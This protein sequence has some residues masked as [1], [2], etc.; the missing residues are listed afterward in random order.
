MSNKTLIASAA[1]L[2][3]GAASVFAG[4]NSYTGNVMLTTDYV[5][6]GVSQTQERGAIQGGFD[7]TFAN[8]LFAGVWASNVNFGTGADGASAEVDYYGGYS[9]ALS[10]EGCS[11]KLVAYYY[12]YEGD[13]KFDYV[14]GLVSFTYGGFTAGLN[15]SP[16]YI[17]D[18]TTDAIGKKVKLY[19]P[20]LNYGYT[21]PGDVALSLHVGYNKM[22]EDGVFEPAEDNYTDWSAGVSKAFGGFNFALTYL[23]TNIK[24]LF[25][26]DSDDADARVVFSVSK[27]L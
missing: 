6:R 17:G 14:E 12:R 27:S 13:K 18:A 19:Y 20:F 11:Y 16:E 24:D 3:L 2:L 22:S 15:Y 5:F 10:C 1:A 9:G 4:E 23:D 26:V 21:L 25:G 8:G 7:A